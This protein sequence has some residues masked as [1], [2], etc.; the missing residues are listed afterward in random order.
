MKI[1]TFGTGIYAG[2]LAD[3]GHEVWAVDLWQAHL[4]AIR[5]QGLRVEGASGDRIVKSI[6]ATSDAAEAGRCDLYAT[7]ASGVAAGARAIA[8]LMGPD[9][10]V[11][12]I[13]N[14]LGA[15]ERI[16]QYMPPTIR[17]GTLMPLI[18]HFPSD[19]TLTSNKRLWRGMRR[20]FINFKGIKN[21]V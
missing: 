18:R 7:K 21:M 8:P 13:Q 20:S 12:T 10:L 17:T 6:H 14:G 19:S 15:G 2:L 16:A 3:A 9:S 11:L 4:D 5:T 1:M